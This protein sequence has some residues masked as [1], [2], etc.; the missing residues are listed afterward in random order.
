M[1]PKLRA[2]IAS[3]L[4][5]ALAGP[6]AAQTLPPNLP[7]KEQLANDNNL[8]VSLA[9]KMLK[10]EESTEPV[11]IVGPIYF[12]G[13]KGLGVFLFT[14]PEGHILTNTGII[15]SSGNVRSFV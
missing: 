12:V 15:P 1:S 4:L 6:T 3:I 5:L 10:C 11:R 13:T 8:F 14:T 2:T 7:S 9:K